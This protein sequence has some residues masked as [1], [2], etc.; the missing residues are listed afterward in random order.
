[1][2]VPFIPEGL[3]FPFF[4]RDAVLIPPVAAPDLTLLDDPVAKEP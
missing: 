3:S 1:M 4:L 2:G